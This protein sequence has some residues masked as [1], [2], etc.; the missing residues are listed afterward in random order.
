MSSKRIEDYA[1]IGDGET[2]ALVDASGTIEWLC[3]PRFDS[4]A[5]FAALLGAQDNGCWRITVKG[6][7]SEPTRRYR[8]DSL[9]LE[10]E[11]SGPEGKV[12]LIDFMP[13]RGEAPDVVRIVECLGGEVELTSELFLRFDYGRIHP[14]VHAVSKARALAVSGPDAVSLDFDD[15]IAFADRRFT[16][17]ARLS[18]GDRRCF[19][20]TWYSSHENPPDRVDPAEALEE[21][22][23]YWHNWLK[24]M[25]HTG[26]YRDSVARSLIT[27]KAMIDRRTGGI[28]AAP[29]ASL[30]EHIG[31][32]RNWDYRYCWLRDATF[33]LTA[34]IEVGL[35]GDAEKWIDWLRRAVGGDPID[36]RPFY[37]VTGQPRA[38][39]WEA[40]WLSG[41][42]GSRPVRFG[43]GA[44]GQ[45]QLDVF[46]EVID[47]LWKAREAGL[48]DGGASEALVRMI[49]DKLTDVWQQEDAGIWEERSNPRQRTY[50]KAM[51]WVAF[52]RAAKWFE[53]KDD[54][55]YARY[56]ALAD[57][58]RAL[59]L[60]KG[61]NAARR[62]FT[63]G[64]DTEALDAALLRLPMIGIIAADDP[65]MIATIDAFEAE[66]CENGLM[67][68]YDPSQVDDGMDGGEGAFVAAC[69][70]LVDAKILQ[71]KRDE[72]RALFERLLGRANDVGLLA[73]E[74]DPHSDRQL[75]NFPQALSHLALVRSAWLLDHGPEMHRDAV[76]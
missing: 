7:H 43:N 8:K 73:E 6:Q 71:G 75:G 69:F 65:R 2:A 14:L 18:K 25:R 16:T 55:L 54:D 67:R 36:L 21:T 49:A 24:D 59:V 48:A 74:F 19:V 37:S 63:R 31:G 42:E 60:D 5:C 72:A 76:Q 4:E 41:F 34:L 23:H 46:G 32:P 12:R 22:E 47:C 50:S 61:W 57:E 68:R 64:F 62:S 17:R 28:V 9:I 38:L 29:T 33:S 26:R 70:W 53:G 44:Q 11:L 10:T 52:D 3:L 51:V 27:L 40:D 15:P 66:L 45:L 13:V 58:V 20:L 1:L 39:E 35:T 56:R 30:P